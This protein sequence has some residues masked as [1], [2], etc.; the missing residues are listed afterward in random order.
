VIA[1]AGLVDL[2][3]DVSGKAR[4]HASLRRRIY[5]ILAEAQDE[6]ANLGKLERR[7]IDIYADEPPCM[8]AVNALAHNS[9]LDSFE[10]PKE[11]RMKIAWWQRFFR[12]VWPFPQTDFKTFEELDK[13][14]VAAH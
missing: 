5:D 1:F 13:A 8:H 7:L 6:D 14:R 3:F 10:R 9:A 12:N 11:L 2:V 4:L